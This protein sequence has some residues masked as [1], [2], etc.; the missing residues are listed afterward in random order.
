MA[1]VSILLKKE[2]LKADGTAPIYFRVINN[3][4]TTFVSSQIY[5][6]PSEWDED[7]IRVKVKNKN[8]ERLNA[9]LTQK[10]GEL[11]ASLLSLKT[12]PNT[13]KN[14][15]KEILTGKPQ[16]DF[17]EFAQTIL[18]RYLSSNRVST[19]DKCKS[20]LTKLQIYS[21]NKTL[22][23]EDI[24]TFFISKYETYLRQTCNNKT[25]TIHA[26]LK[27]I[28]QVF[29]EAIQFDIIPIST[30][31]FLKYKLKLEKTE[32]TYLTEEEL[33]K[34][35]S[36]SLIQGTKMDIHRDMFVF[37]TYAGGLRV[38]DL[39]SLRWSNFDGSHIYSTARKTTSQVAIKLPQK[40][41]AILDKYKANSIVSNNFIFPVISNENEPKDA[42]EWDLAISRATAY[43][44]K[45]LKI[46][47]NKTGLNK[48]LS[49]HIGRHTFA[50]RALTKGISIDKVSKLLGHSA[51]RQTQIYA[52]IIGKE[53]DNAMDA[54]NE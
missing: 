43:Y 22:A 27:F 13:S 34:I 38:S 28:R 10:K 19:H 8:S 41:I 37:T 29:L 46:I 32:R 21:K 30:N 16:T 6:K 4:K 35:E 20:I 54:F 26:N 36:L 14:K 1:T 47:A 18:D 12:E 52:K 48:N 51:I 25:N 49:S 3:R 33:S 53:L 23:F 2:K 39:V 17:F 11:E 5:I 7:K 9:F 45:N 44:N 31:P 24:D 40:A 50:T 42:F 15:I